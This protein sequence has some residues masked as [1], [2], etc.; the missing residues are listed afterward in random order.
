MR[1]NAVPS[2]LCG[3]TQ[4]SRVR[5]HA[6]RRSTDRPSEAIL[7]AS[8]FDFDTFFTGRPVILAPMEDVS[9]APFRQVCRARGAELCV[10]EFVNVEGLLR[11]VRDAIRKIQLT[12]EDQPTAIQIY[13]ADADRLAEA[14]EVAAG[15]GP[16]FLDINCGCWVPK[17]ARRG[18]G[19]GWLR[20]PTAM[21]EMAAMVVKRVAPMPVTVK[22][23]IGWGPESEMPIIELAKRLEAVGVRALTIHCRTAQMGHT[24]AAD[25]TWAKRAKENVRIPVIVN[26]DVRSGED[27][28]T[29]IESTGGAGAMVG[30][31]AIEHPWVFREARALL[32][33]GEVIAPPT[34]KERIDLCREHLALTVVERGD[35]RAVRSMRRYWPGYLRGLHG[36]SS[37]RRDLNTTDSLEATYARFAQLERDVEEGRGRSAAA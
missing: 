20:D 30:R 16:V 14:A 32:D 26:G 18:A 1:K 6:G 35:V 22:T 24:G 8:M 25:W 23:R 4:M 29:A 33:R 12:A 27:A 21:V 11:G 10:T 7:G 2:A 15:A 13:G 34:A 36:G 37:L 17:I 3:L 19:A 5:A 9:D 28:R 31:Y